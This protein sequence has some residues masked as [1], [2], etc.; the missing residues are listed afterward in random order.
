[1]GNV[2]FIFSYIF[3][4]CLDTYIFK[5]AGAK[6]VSQCVTFRTRGILQNKKNLCEEAKVIVKIETVFFI[7]LNLIPGTVSRSTP[8]MLCCFHHRKSCKKYFFHL[9]NLF[10]LISK[11]L[12]ELYLSNSKSKIYAKTI[13]SIEEI[14]PANISYYKKFHLNIAALHKL[15]SVIYWLPKID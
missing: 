11:L 1:M 5:N 15:L 2:Y 10:K 8:Q 7:F 13:H 9:L 12:A 3:R 14:I 4:V 6:Q